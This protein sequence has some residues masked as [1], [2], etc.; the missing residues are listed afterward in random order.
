MFH[1]ETSDCAVQAELGKA[2]IDFIGNDRNIE[3][4]YCKVTEEDGTPLPGHPFGLTT[5]PKAKDFCDQE[6][7]LVATQGDDD[8]VDAMLT[9][10]RMF[11][12]WGITKSDRVRLRMIRALRKDSNVQEV[13]FEIDSTRGMFMC[14]G[15]T[16][17]YDGMGPSSTNKLRRAFRL[18]ALL[19]GIPFDE[20][21]I[22]D[23]AA[24]D[25]RMKLMNLP[26]E[27]RQKK[28]G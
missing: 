24:A 13:F 11:F 15:C 22:R 23:P 4:K 12:R 10:L 26:Y 20:I 1:V 21:L 9:I 6:F 19:F 7:T 16:D 5:V 27:H 28:A 2:L 18:V 3:R 14:C 8:T 17:G 25:M